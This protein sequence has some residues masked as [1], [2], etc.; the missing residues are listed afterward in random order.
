MSGELKNIDGLK[1]GAV[2]ILTIVAAAF[3]A[4]HSSGIF[5]SGQSARAV[6]LSSGPV[7]VGRACGATEQVAAVRLPDGGIVEALVPSSR[8]LQPGT[9]VTV[10]HQSYTCNPASYEIVSDK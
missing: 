9:L 7:N 2:A 6:V 4:L 5:F 3:W 8:P 10:R 1:S